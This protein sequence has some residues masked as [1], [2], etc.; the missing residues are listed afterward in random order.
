[1][2]FHMAEKGKTLRKK[3]TITIQALTIRDPAAESVQRPA[4]AWKVQGTNSGGEKLPVQW[5]PDRPWGLPSLL[6]NGYWAL[7]GGKGAVAV[8]AG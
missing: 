1:M 7:R 8:A 4:K 6:Y 3:Y 5:C 2:V